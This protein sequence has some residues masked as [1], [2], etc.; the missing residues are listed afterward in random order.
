MNRG[1]VVCELSSMMPASV[2][3][4]HLWRIRAKRS[5]RFLHASRG[6]AIAASYTFFSLFEL[7]KLPQTTSG[8]VTIVEHWSSRTLQVGEAGHGKRLAL[9]APPRARRRYLHW[10]LNS[11]PSASPPP[12]SPPPALPRFY[13]KSRGGTIYYLCANAH[14]TS[15][16]RETSG[17]GFTFASNQ[18]TSATGVF[19]FEFE[20]VAR[21]RPTPSNDASIDATGRAL[22]SLANAAAKVATREFSNGERSL[23]VSTAYNAKGMIDIA[24]LFWE[25][26]HTTGVRGALLLSS[27]RIAC[28]ASRALSAAATQLAHC[29]VPS[30]VGARG[31]SATQLV[32]WNR[33]TPN[34]E[35]DRNTLEERWQQRCKLRML[36]ELLRLGH[37]MVYIDVQVLTMKP[38]YLRELASASSPHDVIIGHDAIGGFDDFNPGRCLRIP[39]AYSSLTSNWVDAGQAFFKATDATRWLLSQAE[40]LTDDWV[41]SDSDALQALLLGHAQV[42]DPLRASRLSPAPTNPAWLKPLWLSADKEPFTARGLAT[43]RWIRPLNAPLHEDAWQHIVRQRQRLNFSWG[44]LPEERFASSTQ[45]LQK[46]IGG[47][48]SAGSIGLSTAKDEDTAVLPLSVKLGC[49]AVAWLQERGDDASAIFRGFSSSASPKAPRV[50]EEAPRTRGAGSRHNRASTRPRRTGPK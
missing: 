7:H 42:A 22:P 45:S 19:L 37:D 16:L 47:G 34:W 39:S 38:Q 13:M 36:S 43:E 10:H 14:C 25:W 46:F 27:D 2:E 23:V 9:T 33:N 32:T 17:G 24:C 30:D 40:K 44:W 1:A 50:I 3:P 4:G 35:M 21:A 49:Q 6:T 41:L 8:A 11:P 20:R 18:S 12:L 5:G 31:G 15:R 48:S 28:R 26:L 29:L